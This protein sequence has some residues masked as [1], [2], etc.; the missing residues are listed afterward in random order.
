MLELLAYSCT[1]HY[2]I[3]ANETNFTCIY[4]KLIIYNLSV[5]YSLI[6]RINVKRDE[7][8]RAFVCVIVEIFAD[9]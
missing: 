7:K 3:F 1:Y 4:V 2:A 9:C 8:M 6:I 5:Y